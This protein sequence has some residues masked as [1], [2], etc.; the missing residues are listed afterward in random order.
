MQFKDIK[1]S[2][3]T[4]Y[5]LGKNCWPAA[6]LR[7]Y[8]LR[9]SSGVLDW[10]VSLSLS[11][12]NSLL[13]N[14]FEGFLELQNLSFYSY[15]NNGTELQIMDNRYNII[16][17]HDFK[18]DVNTSTSLPSYP[19]VKD[20]YNRRIKLFLEKM[21]TSEWILFIRTGGTYNEAVELQDIL[22]KL[23]KHNFCVLLIVDTD[24]TL[25][26]EEDWGLKNIC[27]IKSRAANDMPNYDHPTWSMLLNGITVTP[28]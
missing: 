24:S 7:N 13:K 12:V 3:N 18:T 2:Y 11:D 14:R 15:F 4:V 22:S 20:K 21:E 16:S 17:S 19:E 26:T 25:I 28:I 6:A 10:N 27:V 8:G 23:V 9:L 1:R 5:S